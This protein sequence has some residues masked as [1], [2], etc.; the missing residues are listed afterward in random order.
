M[1]NEFSFA[2]EFLLLLFCTEVDM[3]VSAV[4]TLY[5]IHLLKLKNVV[6]NLIKYLKCFLYHKDEL[7]EIVLT[8][9]TLVQITVFN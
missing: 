1:E 7:A 6:G 2:E 5:L 9:G 3:R 4:I 8:I